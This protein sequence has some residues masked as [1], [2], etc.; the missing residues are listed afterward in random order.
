[1]PGKPPASIWAI[2]ARKT[3]RT[4]GAR[5]FYGA[6]RRAHS[7]TLSGAHRVRA[8]RQHFRY[9]RYGDPGHGPLL[10]LNVRPVASGCAGRLCRHERTEQERPVPVLK[11]KKCCLPKDE[12]VRATH[13]SRGRIFHHRGRLLS[14]SGNPSSETLDLAADYFEKKDA[15]EGFAA[16]I[17]RFSQPLINAAGP[18]VEKI[19]RA[20]T[21]GAIFWNVAISGEDTE[22][23]LADLMQGMS[24]TD[25]GAAD[26]RAIAAG[27]VERHKDMFPALHAE[28]RER[29][30]FAEG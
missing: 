2:V 6:I 4:A 23:A 30:A 17:A 28:V 18:D 26:F 22:A 5:R 15:G 19:Q 13:G 12:A 24:L 1:M 27:M 20:M 14:I 21:L 8:Q 11:Y 3:Y 25:E 9:A 16:Q 7:D 29:R 10:K